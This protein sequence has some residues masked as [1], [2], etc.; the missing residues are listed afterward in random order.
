VCGD[1][2][3]AGNAE[4]IDVAVSASALSSMSAEMTVSI[5]GSLTLT[6]TTLLGVEIDIATIT[7]DLTSQQ[8]ASTT[9]TTPATTVSFRHPDDVYGVPKSFGSGIVLNNLGHATVSGNSQ[10]QIDFVPG[11]G[12][13]GDINVSGVAGLAGILN[14]LLAT[15]TSDVNSMVINPLN[16]QVTPQLQDQVGVKVGG[17]DVFAL[18]RP[19]CNDPALAG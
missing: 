4:G 11:Y 7:V 9:Q 17:A 16:S 10:V 6:V 15:A 19:S 3:S 14:N 2:T 1:A 5:T 13:D 12:R 8:S 18:P